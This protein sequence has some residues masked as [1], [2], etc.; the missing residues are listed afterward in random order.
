MAETLTIDTL[1][2]RLLADQSQKRTVV[3]LAG[4][5]AA[6]KSTVAEAL[7]TA[8]ISQGASSA[9]LPMDGF[10]YD[11]A[12][13]LE[14]GLLPRKGA[15]QTF[16]AAGL[17]HCLSRLSSNTEVEV[18][19]PVF[20]RA[21]EISRAGARII[22]QDVR[23]ILVEGNYVL[24]NEAPWTALR[25]KFDVTVKLNASLDVLRSRLRARW[26]S[27]ELEEAEINRKIEENDLLNAKTV[28]Q[29]SIEPDFI[30]ETD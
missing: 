15:Q 28:L 6:G 3:A 21:L 24:L 4:P 26:E 18:A 23:F 13:L 10:H 7:E 11:D 5:P 14:R 20:D 29:K 30:I 27:F 8:L 25:P 9:I 19:V 12:V 17:L 22:L 2:S 1:T 16:D